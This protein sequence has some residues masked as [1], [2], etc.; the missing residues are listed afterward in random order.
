VVA[1]AVPP[2]P[3]NVGARPGE[4][5]ALEPGFAGA[6]AGGDGVGT[7]MSEVTRSLLQRWGASFRRGADFDSWGQLVE[8]IDEYQM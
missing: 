7:A 4:D 2:G 8:A 5:G 1:V 3:V 6:G